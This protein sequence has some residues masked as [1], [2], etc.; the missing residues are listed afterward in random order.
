[1]EL[2]PWRSRQS[3]VS[4]LQSEINRMF[5]DFFNQ[6]IALSLLQGGQS[7]RNQAVIPAV[8]V[9]E[10]ESNVNVTVELPG[11]DVN[12]VEISVQGD[13]L[14]LRGQKREEQRDEK[15]NYCRVE[16]TYG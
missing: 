13:M 6:P 2:M 9:E 1:M 4:S 15:G 5:E 12:D 10:D 7:N 11:I 8:D 16:R 14:E 3:P